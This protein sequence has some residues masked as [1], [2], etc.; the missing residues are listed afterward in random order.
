[1]QRAP[2]GFAFHANLDGDALADFVVGA[3]TADHS[4]NNG[5]AFYVIEGATIATGAAE[6]V[7]SAIWHTGTP[8][9]QLGACISTGGDLDGDGRDDILAGSPGASHRYHAECARPYWDTIT[10]VLARLSSFRR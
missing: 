1:M 5:G 6:D 4:G 8:S 2:R 9:E 7:A 10:P 3:P